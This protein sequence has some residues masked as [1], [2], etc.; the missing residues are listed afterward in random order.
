MN[1]E[2]VQLIG[3]PADGKEVK[4]PQ[5]LRQWQV[6]VVRAKPGVQGCKTRPLGTAVYAREGESQKFLYQE[7]R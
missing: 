4:I 2:L 7:T 3:G 1:L 6:P 5:G